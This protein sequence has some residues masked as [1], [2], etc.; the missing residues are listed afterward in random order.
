MIINR[1]RR[2]V[3]GLNTTS[4]A[5]ISFMLLIFFL[6]TTSMD[7][8]KGLARMLPQRQPKNE[9][10]ET[11]IERA[12]LIAVSLGAGDSLTVNGRSS[13]LPSLRREIVETVSARGKRHLIT[14]SCSR[15]ARYD[16]YFHLQNT[17]LDAYR[18]VRER[19]ARRAYGVAWS[20]LGENRRRQLSDM[21]PQRIAESYAGA[22][23]ADS[24]A[25]QKGGSK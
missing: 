19:A 22:A 9:Q 2:R 13:D 15:D 24:A 4:T 10:V 25:V 6:V 14:L 17:I 23:T 20:S 8:D 18:D 1:R 21:Y 16:A 3:P 11:S 7:I 12:G 5:D